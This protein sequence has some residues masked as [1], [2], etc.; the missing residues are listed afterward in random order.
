MDSKDSGTKV[1]SR[2]DNRFADVCFILN[3]N[4]RVSHFPISPS[5]FR[6]HFCFRDV[7][8]DDVE[9]PYLLPTCGYAGPTCGLHTRLV[10]KQ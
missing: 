6:D 8:N 10:E 4:D 3:C 1:I 5:E 9:N 7:D 2:I